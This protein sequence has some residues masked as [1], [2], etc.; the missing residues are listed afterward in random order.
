MKQN[1]SV[2][3]PSMGKEVVSDFVYEGKDF[4]IL[5]GNNWIKLF[6][7]PTKM[8]EAKTVQSYTLLLNGFW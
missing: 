7:S 5:C 2:I 8:T 6:S 4:L 3:F 1:E